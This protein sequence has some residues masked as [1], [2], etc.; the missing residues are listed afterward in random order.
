MR[1]SGRSPRKLGPPPGWTPPVVEHKPSERTVDTWPII[2]MDLG[3]E[4]CMSSVLLPPRHAGT[5]LLAAAWQ[6]WRDR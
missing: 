1:R 6:K 2:S 5:M 4:S 3:F